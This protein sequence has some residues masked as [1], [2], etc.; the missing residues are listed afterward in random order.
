MSRMK[1]EEGR[2]KIVD[3]SEKKA[4]SRSSIARGEIRLKP[5]T[6]D[7]IRAGKV[8]KGDVLT[9]AKVSAVLAAKKTSEIIPACHNIP[10]EDIEIS[11]EMRR[12]RIVVTCQVKAESKTGVEMEA[13]SGTCIALLTIWDMIKEFEKDQKGQY[14]S[15]SLQDIR[16]V[17][18]VKA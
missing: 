9:V 8:P 3:I 6:L 17:E 1:G 5:T 11:F 13:L 7:A 16:V 4:S 18:K 10:I 12:D 15:T 2:L 14:P